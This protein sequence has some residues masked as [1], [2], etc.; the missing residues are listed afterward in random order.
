MRY[1]SPLP[2][3]RMQRQW[4][5]CL[6]IL[7]STGSIGRSA[8]SFLR[9]HKDRFRVAALAGGK[10]IALLAEQAGEFRP[11]FLAVLEEAS[12]PELRARLPQGYRPEIMAGQ[13]G[14]ECLAALPEV[15]MLL[16]AQSGAAGLRATY[17]AV[18]A[19]K[20]IALA[21]KES[22]VLAGSLIRKAC[23]QSGA[24]I[25]PV[26]S[27]H[28]AIFQCMCDLLSKADRAGPN[29]PDSSDNY[30]AGIQRL[31]LTASGGPFR[32]LG[33][34]E[35]DKVTVE[36]ALAHP[37]WSM[38]PKIT[39]DSATLM[40]KGLEL[41]EASHLYGL[42]MSAIDVV[43]HRESIIH[44][45]VEFADGSQL[46][47]LG[48]PDMRVPIGYCLSWPERLHT[49]TDRLDLTMMGSLHFTLPDESSFPALSLARR[50]QEAGRGSPVVLNAANEEA[51]AAFLDRRIPFRSIAAF[52]EHCLDTYESGGFPGYKT[53]REPESVEDILALDAETR[54]QTRT[55]SV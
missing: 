37:N 8:L 21:N 52:V 50:A 1:I 42:P 16:S 41:I 9:L 24:C 48:M 18:Q 20:I 29:S 39:I 5:R 28:N 14:Y 38:G 33:K 19:G 12:V 32:D 36:Q 10:N 11:A 49:G 46:A 53:T 4:P 7:G 27:E 43:V 25:L 35:L 45:L 40:N 31:I 47:Q 3:E 26:D 51:V 34:E 23:E 6:A 44:S 13:K 2:S 30:G 55:S 54:A 17:A 15:D 22:L